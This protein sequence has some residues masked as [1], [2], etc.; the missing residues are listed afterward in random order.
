M[1][2]Y[3]VSGDAHVKLEI[4]NMLGQKIRTLVNQDH[5]AGTYRAVWDAK[6]NNGNTVSTGLYFYVLKSEGHIEKRKAV[7]MK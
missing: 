6:N 4:Y 1:I 7:L 2:E 5:T 3:Q